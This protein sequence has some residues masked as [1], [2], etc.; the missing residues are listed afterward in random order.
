MGVLSNT[1][2]DAIEQG[3]RN[4][5]NAVYFEGFDDAAVVCMEIISKKIEGLFN[6]I[7]EGNSLSG[8]EQFLLAQLNVLKKE[9]DDDLI[10]FAKNGE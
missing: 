4:V 5:R 1:L 7:N 10:R 2:F 9:I 6:K 8:Q 3:R